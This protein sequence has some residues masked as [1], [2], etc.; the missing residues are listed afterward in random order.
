MDRDVMN[1]LN[2][3]PAPNNPVNR[4]EQ[5]QDALLGWMKAANGIGML[6][7][8]DVRDIVTKAN[9]AYSGMID[10]TLNKKRDAALEQR[11]AWEQQTSMLAAVNKQRLDDYQAAFVNNL[12]IEEKMYRVADAASRWGDEAIMQMA[13]SGEHFQTFAK[14]FDFMSKQQQQLEAS[15]KTLDDE[16]KQIEQRIQVPQQ[17]TIPPISPYLS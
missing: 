6:A 10:N 4:G 17:Q 16:I 15:T 7:S 8:Q 3:S 14:Y 13:E 2:G 1:A 11:K 12:P 5:I 9:E